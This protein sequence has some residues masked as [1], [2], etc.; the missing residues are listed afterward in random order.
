MDLAVLAVVAV[1]QSCQQLEQ[2]VGWP[3]W[4]CLVEEGLQRQLVQPRHLPG[5]DHQRHDHH[6][7]GLGHLCLDRK[8]AFAEHLHLPQSLE[9]QRLAFE[10][11]GLKL[12]ARGSPCRKGSRWPFQHLQLC[13]DLRKRSQQ[14][15]WFEG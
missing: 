4:S 6:D 2:L 1:W 9:P 14:D 15:D 7:H 3:R 12:F 11:V 5:L 13:L 8:I 10:Q